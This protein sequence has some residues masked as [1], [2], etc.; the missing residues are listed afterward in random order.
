MGR[1]KG[2]G[3]GLLAASALGIILYVWLVFFSSWSLFVL[4]V[5]AAAAVVG[6]LGLLGWIGYVVATT[7]PPATFLPPEEK[8]VDEPPS[9]TT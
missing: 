8:P 2:V 5:T 6:I 3:I 1:E 4:E 9:K 7:P